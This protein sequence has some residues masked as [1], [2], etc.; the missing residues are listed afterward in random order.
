[1]AALYQAM[2]PTTIVGAAHAVVMEEQFV[3]PA[4][5]RHAIEGISRQGVPPMVEAKQILALGT[6][7]ADPKRVKEDLILYAASIGS[8]IRDSRKGIPQGHRAAP[9]PQKVPVPLGLSKIDIVHKKRSYRDGK[10]A[11]AGI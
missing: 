6:L 5:L 7:K 3:G 2:Q 4:L 8:R 10:F 9:T 11:L 1:M